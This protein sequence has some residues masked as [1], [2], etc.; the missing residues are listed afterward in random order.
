MISLMFFHEVSFRALNSVLFLHFCGRL[1]HCDHFVNFCD[2]VV[3]SW[4]VK[5]LLIFRDFMVDGWTVTTL[6]IFV[7]V[8]GGWTVTTLF[9]FVILW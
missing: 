4:T 2:F 6:F 8:V 9:I 7:T 1:L 5:A 3:G